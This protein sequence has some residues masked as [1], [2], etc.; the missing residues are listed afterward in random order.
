MYLS[1]C[2]YAISLFIPAWDQVAGVICLVFGVV[3]INE[4]ILFL[5]WLSNIFIAA[6]WVSFIFSKEYKNSLFLSVM[7][8]L[9]SLTILPTKHSSLVQSGYYFWVA[10]F[11][12]SAIAAAFA[13]TD[14]KHFQH[15]RSFFSVEL[16]SNMMDWKIQ[17]RAYCQAATMRIVVVVSVVVVLKNWKYSSTQR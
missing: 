1:V 16:A 3:T 11:I 17:Y 8:I 13:I 4:P 12:L 9:L 10:S 2:I 14:E 15:W 5:C 6:A 7:A